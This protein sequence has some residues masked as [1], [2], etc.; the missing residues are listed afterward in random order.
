MPKNKKNNQLA[1]LKRYL[2]SL[3][4]H[5][6]LTVVAIIVLYPLLWVIGSSFDPIN[7]IEGHT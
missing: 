6:E 1:I 7:D 4:I 2:V 3:L 5:L